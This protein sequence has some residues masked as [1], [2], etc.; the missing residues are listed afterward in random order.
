M[1]Q[2]ECYRDVTLCQGPNEQ[3]SLVSTGAALTSHCFP[4]TWTRVTA[5]AIASL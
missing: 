2:D 3:G 5:I 4:E 1:T